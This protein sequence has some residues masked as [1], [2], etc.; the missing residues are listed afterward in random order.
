M[1]GKITIW[2]SDT[3]TYQWDYKSD[4]YTMLAKLLKRKES[5]QAIVESTSVTEKGQEN[6]QQ[7]PL[8]QYRYQRPDLLGKVSLLI[9]FDYF[10]SCF[11][12]AFVM[13]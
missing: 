1:G 6:G 4:T 10:V 12:C 8:L 13:I 11:A 5:R 9:N 7:Q 2:I 3:Q